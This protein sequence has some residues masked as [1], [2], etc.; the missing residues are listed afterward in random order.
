MAVSKFLPTTKYKIINTIPTVIELPAIDLKL[1]SN[2]RPGNVIE[3]TH[4]RVS[5]MQHLDFFSCQATALFAVIIC[6]HK[7]LNKENSLTLGS[8]DFKNTNSIGLARLETPWSLSLLK[9]CLPLR[10]HGGIH[11]TLNNEMTVFS[12]LCT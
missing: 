2:I 6:G 4:R 5:T 7:T 11:Y 10:M 3:K 9:A 12:R 8:G 1:N